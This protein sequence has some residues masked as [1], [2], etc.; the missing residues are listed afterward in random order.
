MYYAI[1]GGFITVGLMFVVWAVP[2]EFRWYVIAIQLIS[3]AAQI[4][5]GVRMVKG[6]K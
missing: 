3:L 4:V 2:A 5:S 1:Y 6:S